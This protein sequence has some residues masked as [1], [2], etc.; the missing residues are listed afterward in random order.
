MSINC[1]LKKTFCK[2]GFF[3]VFSFPVSFFCCISFSLSSAFRFAKSLLHKSV[4]IKISKYIFEQVFFYYSVTGSFNNSSRAI[5]RFSTILSS[6]IN[7]S[8]KI[9]VRLLNFAMSSSCVTNPMV[10]PSSFNC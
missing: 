7:P 8:R 1:T 3:I 5:H 9:T 10:I 6:L 2:P 4:F